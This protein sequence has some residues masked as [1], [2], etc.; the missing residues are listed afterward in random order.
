MQLWKFS[1]GKPPCSLSYLYDSIKDIGNITTNVESV[2]IKTFLIGASKL[3]PFPAR[4]ISTSLFKA[5]KDGFFSCSL[6][7]GVWGCLQE[8]QCSHYFSCKKFHRFA[9]RLPQIECLRNNTKLENTL[10]A[11]RQRLQDSCFTP[12]LIIADNS[13][14]SSVKK[15]R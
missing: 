2:E 4:P 13:F 3:L 7:F 12:N 15:K 10:Q 1:G 5:F 6:D 9:R 14:P 11:L 8:I